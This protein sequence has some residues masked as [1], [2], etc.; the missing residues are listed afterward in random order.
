[1][2]Y[3]LN[4]V[5]YSTN[6]NFFIENQVFVVKTGFIKLNEG[7]LKSSLRDKL[8]INKKKDTPTVYTI[9]SFKVCSRL[10]SRSFEEIHSIDNSSQIED[11]RII[12]SKLLKGVYGKGKFIK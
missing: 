2:W 4:G 3:E 11:I 10:E 12:H 8:I 5:E 6:F 9:M 1:M 7:Y